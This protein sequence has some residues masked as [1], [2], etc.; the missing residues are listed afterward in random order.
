V[1][2]DESDRELLPTPR[3]RLNRERRLRSVSQSSLSKATGISERTLQRLENGEIEN[4]PL[5]YLVNCAKALG[6]DDWRE[7]VD[8]EWERWLPLPGGPKRA[9]RAKSGPGVS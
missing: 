4:P 2:D 5:R 7:L 3:T 8:P 9:R 6:I 1:P